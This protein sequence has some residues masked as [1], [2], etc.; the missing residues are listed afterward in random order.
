[1][2][3]GGRRRVASVIIH[4]PLPLLPNLS[5]PLSLSSFD[6]FF[7]AFFIDRLVSAIFDGSDDDY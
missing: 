1:M 7:F 3:V 2:V 4:N 5:I 6:A